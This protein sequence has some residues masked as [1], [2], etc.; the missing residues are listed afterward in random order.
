MKARLSRK[1]LHSIERLD[2]FVNESSPERLANDMFEVTLN[3]FW[4]SMILIHLD[5]WIVKGA[6]AEALP[7]LATIRSNIDSICGGLSLASVS[8]AEALADLPVT[9]SIFHWIVLYLAFHPSRFHGRDEIG[10]RYLIKLI[11]VAV[12]EMVE[13]SR[14]AA[15]C[16]HGPS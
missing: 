8:D 3:R 4:C 16:E 11:G 6:R 13:R 14:S 15:L 7:I 10:W 5:R 12:D 9:L 1:T 2:Q